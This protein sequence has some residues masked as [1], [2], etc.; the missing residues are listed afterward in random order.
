[1]GV[2]PV[3]GGDLK[4]EIRNQKL[5]TRFRT[6]SHHEFARVVRQIIR[7]SHLISM[8]WDVVLPIPLYFKVLPTTFLALC[9]S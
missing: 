4:S 7:I 5:E 1:M 2:M 8:V 6:P 3:E 9:E